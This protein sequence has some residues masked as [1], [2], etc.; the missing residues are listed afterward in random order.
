[1]VWMARRHLGR[2]VLIALGGLLAAGLLYFLVW[3][4]PLDPVAVPLPPV[5][6]SSA[7]EH[8][9]MLYLGH[10]R[11]LPILRLPLGPGLQ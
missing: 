11:S 10:G 1:M 2:K 8:G 9:N 4:G 3:P 5:S 7:R 6:L